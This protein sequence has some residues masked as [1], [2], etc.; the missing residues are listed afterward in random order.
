MVATGGEC[1]AGDGL[2]PGM[3]RR[4][5]WGNVGRAAG[6]TAALALVVAWPRL[7]SPPPRLPADRAVPFAAAPGPAPAARLGAP[8]RPGLRR[9]S[10][11]NA[12]PPGRIARAR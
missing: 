8:E 2:C 10:A 11:L 12:A 7:A 5:R 4:V 9:S 1:A 3:P 6:A